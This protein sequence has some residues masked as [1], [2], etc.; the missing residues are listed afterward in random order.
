MMNDA[1]V[2]PLN[3]VEMERIRKHYVSLNLGMSFEKSNWQIIDNRIACKCYF[4]DRVSTVF[5]I[6][7]HLDPDRYRNELG[8]EVANDYY[9][10]IKKVQL[11]RLEDQM[12]VL[13]GEIAN[14]EDSM[15]DRVHLMEHKKIHIKVIGLSYCSKHMALTELYKILHPKLGLEETFNEGVKRL[16]YTHFT[17]DTKNDSRKFGIGDFPE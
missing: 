10:Q 7:L 13:R 12:E 3:K 2:F 8:E 1:S 16:G 5:A 11:R 14:L 6:L 17:W 15:P 4:V 9:Y